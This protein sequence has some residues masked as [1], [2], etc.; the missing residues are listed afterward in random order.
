MTERVDYFKEAAINAVKNNNEILEHWKHSS[1]PF[2]RALAK[3]VFLEA[4]GEI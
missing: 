3:L 4:K 1:N 2:D